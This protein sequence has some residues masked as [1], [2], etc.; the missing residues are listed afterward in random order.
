MIRRLATIARQA[1]QVP[2][3]NVYL[4]R[5]RAIWFR[6]Q[7]EQPKSKQHLLYAESGYAMSLLDSGENEKALKVLNHYQ[8]SLRRYAPE[9]FDRMLPRVGLLMGVAFLRIGETENCL[10]NHTIDSC[11]F[12]IQDKGVHRLPRGSRSATQVF[13]QLLAKNPSD[14][15]AR[16]LLNIAEMTLGNYPGGLDEVSLIPA[17]RF[18]SEA[19]F[20]RFPDLAGSLGLDVDALCGGSVVDD[21]DGDGDLD[22][23]MS[24]FG[25]ND[26]LRHF[27][28]H[29]D[30]GFKD[31]T[32]ESGLQGL[33]G[34][35]N[36]VHA[37]Y[38][39][40]GDLDL[41]VLRGGWFGP[42]GEH[43]N[44][45]LRNRGD[46]SFD[47]VTESAGL[48]SF[49]PTQTAVWLDFDND[50]WLDLFIG[51]ES[52]PGHEH[53]CE[54][55]RNNRDGSFTNV[56]SKIGAAI[57]GFVKGVVAADYD[58][59]GWSDIYI[60]CL[61]QPNQ[62]LRNTVSTSSGG[63]LRRFVDQ[64]LFAGVD[65]P[66]D[67]FT[68]WFWDFDNDGWEDLFVSG[69]RLG[70]VG[71]MALD[72][73]G[74]PHKSEKP[75]LYRNLGDGTFEE[76][77]E[78]MGMSH[79]LHTM[80]AN[81]GDLNNDGFLDCYLGT[82]DS[83][84][85]SLMPNR[86]F[87]NRDGERFLDVTTAGGFG[88]LQKGHGVSFCDLDHDGDQDVY[89][90]MGG[91]VSSDHYRNALF[92]NPGNKNHWLKLSLIGRESNR[93]GIGARIELRLRSE[94][95][96]HRFVRRTV[97]SGGSFGGNP[98]RM[99]IGLGSAE[100]L[101]E[102]VVL[103]PKTQERQRWS[104]LKRDQWYVLEEGR[105]VATRKRHQSFRTATEAVV[106]HEHAH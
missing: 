66:R 83:S 89:T 46:G 6:S 75:R 76:V 9:H 63:T 43:P 55:F 36:L 16:W 31:V 39:N 49:H 2:Q 50:G 88:H 92:E 1:R 59:D 8:R 40:D 25:L 51:N 27:C 73:L 101:E 32:N 34:G 97:S 30:E 21:F 41:F 37:D 17:Q 20:P 80:G 65:E 85:A 12:P 99:E 52:Q 4:S 5:E 42:G 79:L 69:Y 44:S 96:V 94:G 47:D 90:V 56:A 38:D 19:P 78:K 93:C 15:S 33:Y 64:A 60:S 74:M 98:L 26:S 62:L 28:N 18:A 23:V 53:P 54:L 72:Y 7:L 82:G 45:L 58:N 67:S 48:L 81:Y 70:E 100:A 57:V 86:M 14:S 103:W 29:G 71:D 24:S 77:A 106:V 91:A 102:V 84:L 105:A 13:R 104:N 11:L 3:D 95:G 61:G 35:L 22:L 68:T 87:L 10:E